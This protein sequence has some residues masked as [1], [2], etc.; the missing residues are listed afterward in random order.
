MQ[1]QRCSWQ[2]TDPEAASVTTRARVDMRIAK[3]VPTLWSPGGWQPRAGKVDATPTLLCSCSVCSAS[4]YA[5]GAKI[6][7]L[8]NS[9]NLPSRSSASWDDRCN[10]GAAVCDDRVGREAITAAKIKISQRCKRWGDDFPSKLGP[11]RGTDVIA[12]Y[13]YENRINV[14]AISRRTIRCEMQRG[15]DASPALGDEQAR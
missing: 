14:V 15:S 10:A 9:V 11:G 3:G 2:V 1:S 5:R 12:Q 7:R 4:R 13:V 8:G 6:W